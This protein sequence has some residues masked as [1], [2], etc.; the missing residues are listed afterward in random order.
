MISNIPLDISA[1]ICQFL[2]HHDVCY[3][4]AVSKDHNLLMHNNHIWKMLYRRQFPIYCIGSQSKHN[5]SATGQCEGD[6]CTKTNHYKNLQRKTVNLRMYVNFQKQFIK[7]MHTIDKRMMRSYLTRTSQS[8]GFELQCNEEMI[9][10]MKRKI[11]NL[12]RAQKRLKRVH[13]IKTIGLEIM[14][15]PQKD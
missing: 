6:V 5:P 10:G 15:P 2:D 1:H 13:K 14:Y 3:M 8:T 9:A 12:Q 11:G 7:R 4:M